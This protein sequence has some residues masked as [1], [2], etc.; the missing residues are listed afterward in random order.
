[1]NSKIKITDLRERMT[2][3]PII[4]YNDTNGVPAHQY[5]TTGT[6]IYCKV[7]KSTRSVQDNDKTRSV[8]QI[9]FTVRRDDITYKIEDRI[10]WL[11]ATVTITDIT[12]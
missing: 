8:Q 5:A 1:M 3:Y 11:S 12:D 2:L 9:K 7:Q 6:D 10:I 4:G